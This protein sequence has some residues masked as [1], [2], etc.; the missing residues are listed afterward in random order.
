MSIFFSAFAGDVLH[1]L[2]EST[3]R[4]GISRQKPQNILHSASRR[5]EAPNRRALALTPS[6]QHDLRAERVAQP[7]RFAEQIVPQ[8]SASAVLADEAPIGDQLF[9]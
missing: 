4:Y 9:L 7:S 3:R 5:G 2:P 6:D 8:A 1:D